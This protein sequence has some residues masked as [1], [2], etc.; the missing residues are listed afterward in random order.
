M[1]GQDNPWLHQRK[2]PQR[3]RRT[4]T[5]AE[6]MLWRH[7]R[8][9]QMGVKFRRQH[10]YGD[11]VLDFASLEIGLVIEVDGGQHEMQKEHDQVRTDILE[12]AG[13]RVLRFWNNQ[14]LQEMESVLQLIFAVIDEIKGN[15]PSPPLPSP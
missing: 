2:I 1:R 6:Q 15:H 14:V 7:L 11:Y 3:L 13:F 5:D 4:M 12:S 9:N 8:R 10:P